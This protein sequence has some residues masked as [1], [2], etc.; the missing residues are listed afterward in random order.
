MTAHV[1]IAKTARLPWVDTGRG[2]AILLVVLFHSANWL[3]SAGFPVDGWMEINL[4]LSNI[5]LPMFFALSGLF[6]GKWARASWGDIWSV[7]L[8]LFAWVY[9]LWS[10]IATVTFMAGLNLQEEYGNYL[11]QFKPTFQMLWAPRFE[12]WFIWAL[13]LMFVI[14]RLISPLPKMAQ[15]I[16]FG[17]CSAFFLSPIVDVPFGW[18]GLLRYTFFFLAG[19]HMRRQYFALADRAPRRV[20]F[21]I[22][23]VSAILAVM[24][25]VL[26]LNTTVIGYYFLTCCAG[27]VAGVMISRELAR[28]GILQYLGQR[29]LPIYLT[30]TSIIILICWFLHLLPDSI[31]LLPL[32]WLLP[33]LLAVA[34][35]WLALQ[36]SRWV[37]DRRVWQYLYVQPMWFARLGGRRGRQSGAAGRSSRP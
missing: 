30:H 28:F 5:R 27:S 4:V 20:G 32:Y 22:I 14:A 37:Q 29:T 7:K 33:P 26:A 15:L 12:L 17:L 21:V 10:V 35:I 1:G 6:A 9:G 16:P 34:A 3:E 13:A 2:I 11:A 23:A 24:G 8:S 25:T 36:L 19:M 18:Q 31:K